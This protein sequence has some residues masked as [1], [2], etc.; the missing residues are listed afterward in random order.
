MKKHLILLFIFTAI[1]CKQMQQ[2]ISV[3]KQ[4]EF[5]LN[6]DSIEKANSKQMEIAGSNLNKL[7]V[8]RIDST[9]WMNSTMPI[10]NRH[11]IFGYDKPNKKS[12]KL[13]LISI[14]TSDVERN[15]FGFAFG[16][17]YFTD[18]NHY[19]K[20]LKSEE[21]FILANYIEYG[22]LKGK[23]YIPKENVEFKY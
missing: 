9:I 20:Y 6:L 3:A 7:T 18:F 21:D 15:P 12:E 16:A 5:V 23:I 8:S 14:F 1:A 4:A 22:K 13:L 19:M 11:R 10:N 2:K 17:F